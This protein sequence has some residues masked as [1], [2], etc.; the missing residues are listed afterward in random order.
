MIKW[1]IKESK[2]ILS[3]GNKICKWYE[4]GDILG[5]YFYRLII[6]KF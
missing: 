5:V 1:K 6:I 3:R 2:S 4:N